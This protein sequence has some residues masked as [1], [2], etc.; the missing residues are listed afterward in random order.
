MITEADIN[1]YFTYHPPNESQIVRYQK[2]RDA[3][4]VFALAILENTKSSADQTATIRKL[5]EVVMA[6]NQTIALEDYE[7]K[8]AA[9]RVTPLRGV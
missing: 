7:N 5:R 2:V 3:A 1:E 6:A 4:K 8:K 9:A